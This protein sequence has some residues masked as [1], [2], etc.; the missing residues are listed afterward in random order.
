MRL[1]KKKITHTHTQLAQ[2]VEL[3]WLVLGVDGVAPRACVLCARV[4]ACAGAVKSL[5]TY[6]QRG[7]TPRV[8]P[9]LKRHRGRKTRGHQRYRE[10]LFLVDT[11]W[12]VGL[13]R[14]KRSRR[15][16]SSENKHILQLYRPCGTQITI[17][18]S[19]TLLFKQTVHQPQHNSILRRLTCCDKGGGLDK[20][21]TKYNKHTH[22][23]P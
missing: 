2:L 20:L 1:R 7:L 15:D 13:K 14:K 12:K 11:E 18:K 16:R 17:I 6:I 4:R 3:C 22:K 19:Q 10:V 23:Y 5:H 8:N 21:Q 9:N